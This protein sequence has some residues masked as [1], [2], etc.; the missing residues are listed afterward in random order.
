MSDNTIHAAIAAAVKE[1]RIL[2]K[3]EKNTY[4]NYNFVSVDK[5][6]EMLN[7]ICGRHGLFPV[8]DEESHETFASAKGTQWLRVHYAITLH[9][10][11]GGTLGPVRRAVAVPHNGAQAYGSAQSYALK[12]FFRSL[13]MIPTGDRDDPDFNAT[14]ETIGAGTISAAQFIE[15]RQAIEDSGADLTRFLAAYKAPTLEEFPVAEYA[16]AMK[17]LERKK[18]DG[19]AN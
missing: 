15:L 2:G 8:M 11:S 12:Q 17:K 14:D 16:G 1:V 13:L 5:F 4:D 9:H 7:P 3:T 6:L 10:S 18:A 19:T